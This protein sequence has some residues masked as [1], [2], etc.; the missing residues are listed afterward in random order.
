MKRVEVAV[1]N[2]TVRLD[3]L[4]LGLFDG[5]LHKDCGCQM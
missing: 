4:M 1:G 2:Q 5:E 3:A